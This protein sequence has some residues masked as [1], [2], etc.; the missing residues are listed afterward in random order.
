M[1]GG[2]P[3]FVLYVPDA[4]D[5]ARL[6]GKPQSGRAEWAFPQVRA[7]SLCEVGSHVLYKHLLKPVP[8]GEARMADSGAPSVAFRG[9]APWGGRTQRKPEVQ[10]REVITAAR[11]A[12]GR[13][14]PRRCLCS[15]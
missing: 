9:V 6:F 3:G 12:R 8:V 10:S 7:L 4:P 13:R 1:G 5:N 11:C 15:G 14:Q 2:D